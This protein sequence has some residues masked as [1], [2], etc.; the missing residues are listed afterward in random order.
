MPHKRINFWD[1]DFRGG[2]TN[3][4]PRDTHTTHTQHTHTPIHTPRLMLIEMHG[5]ARRLSFFFRYKYIYRGGFFSTSLGSNEVL[6]EKSLP[7]IVGD[8][9]HFAIWQSASCQFTYKRYLDTKILSRSERQKSQRKRPLE[10]WGEG[11]IF[12]TC[13]AT[14]LDLC[15]CRNQIIILFYAYPA[16]EWRG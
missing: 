15:G 7:E 8:K 4:P 2:T 1:S 14:P 13:Q 6:S 12:L 9:S 5:L 11:N 10:C 3:Q 16:Q